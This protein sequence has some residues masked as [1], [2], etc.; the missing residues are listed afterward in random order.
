VKLVPARPRLAVTL[1]PADRARTVAFL[2]DWIDRA[3]NA[4]RGKRTAKGKAA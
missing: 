4:R 3:K 1:A 2:V